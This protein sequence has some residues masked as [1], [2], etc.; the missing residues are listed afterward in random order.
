MLDLAEGET[1]LPHEER[2]GFAGKAYLHHSTGHDAEVL[3]DGNIR[4]CVNGVTVDSSTD[5]QED[6][7]G[8]YSRHDYQ[9][10]CG[11]WCPDDVNYVHKL[12]QMARAR[13]L[14]LTGKRYS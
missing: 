13:V 1:T 9:H 12:Q 2:A 11:G 14:A 7:R 6:G 5:Y 3:S 10:H 4:I 8:R